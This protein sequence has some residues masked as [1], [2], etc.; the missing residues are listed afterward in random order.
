MD[1]RDISQRELPF[2]E[3][4]GSHAERKEKLGLALLKAKADLHLVQ[5][6]LWI[7]NVTDGGV[8]GT[9]RKSYEELGGMPWGLCCGVTKVKATLNRALRLGLVE[10]VQTFVAG[11]GYG[12]NEYRIDWEGVSELLHPGMGATRLRL[13]ASRPRLGAMRPAIEEYTFP[14]TYVSVAG[15]GAGGPR[16]K[17]PLEP[18]DTDSIPELAEAVARRI[19]PLP[20]GDLRYGAFKA[21]QKPEGL[22]NGALVLWFRQQLGLPRPLAGPAESD[23]LLVLAAGLTAAA[24][25]TGDVKKN[26]LAVFSSI[27]SRGHWWKAYG[28]VKAARKLLDSLLEMYPKCCTSPDGLG[29]SAVLRDLSNNGGSNA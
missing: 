26:R 24:M 20:P 10:C 13:V 15:A 5:L 8:R 12:A 2:G 28:Q 14:D 3:A 21:L 29:P 9:L 27:V 19:A 4:E 23:L 22:R 11:G 6:C 25:A 1:S 16:P 7:F 18:A 17:P